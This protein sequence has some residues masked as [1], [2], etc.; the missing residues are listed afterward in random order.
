MSLPLNYSPTPFQLC[1]VYVYQL[2]CWE[3]T[4]ATH[5]IYYTY[6]CLHPCPAKRGLLIIQT[7]GSIVPHG[8]ACC[9]SSESWV[10]WVC[11][12]CSE[13]FFF[14][15]VPWFPLSPVTFDS[16]YVNLMSSLLDTTLNNSN[17]YKIAMVY[18]MNTFYYCYYV[19]I[20]D[21]AISNDI[22]NKCSLIWEESRGLSF[23]AKKFRKSFI[24][25]AKNVTR[26]KRFL[27][28]EGKGNKYDWRCI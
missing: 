25:E 20:I 8:C 11:P 26:I 28:Q 14:F 13:R 15:L 9:M 18:L 3:E 16:I 17:P 6:P 2:S 1:F 22:I 27:Q 10:N 19:I 12:L 4:G 5:Y 7:W 23:T 24:G 21:I